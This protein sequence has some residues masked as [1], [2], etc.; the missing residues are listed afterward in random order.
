MLTNEEEEKE[1]GQKR[2]SDPEMNVGRSFLILV[3]IEVLEA[4]V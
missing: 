2:K 4:W 3:E 1:G